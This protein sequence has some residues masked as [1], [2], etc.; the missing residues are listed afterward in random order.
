MKEA[1]RPENERRPCGLSSGSDSWRIEGL[2]QALYAELNLQCLEDCCGHTCA[3]RSAADF[4]FLQL[5]HV[6][7]QMSK[8]WHGMLYVVKILHACVLLTAHQLHTLEPELSRHEHQLPAAVSETERPYSDLR[9]AAH[10]DV[11]IVGLTHL[12]R[13]VGKP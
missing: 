2:A 12:L 13:L 6:S 7:H 11:K 1:G 4:V 9:Y 10:A 8:P 5:I 3:D